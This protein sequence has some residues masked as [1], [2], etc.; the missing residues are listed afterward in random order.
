MFPIK[1]KSKKEFFTDFNGYLKNPFF[2]LK[3]KYENTNYNVGP[4]RDSHTKPMY[5]THT[6]IYTYMYVLHLGYVFI[7]TYT[8][9]CVDKPLVMSLWSGAPNGPCRNILRGFQ[10]PLPAALILTNSLILNRTYLC[11]HCA[12]G[13]QYLL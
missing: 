13:V 5:N 12:R 9:I 11:V 2:E 6:S 10:T 8:H 3:F 7:Y 1:I 4:N